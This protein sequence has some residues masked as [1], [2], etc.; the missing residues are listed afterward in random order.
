MAY[1][2]KVDIEVSTTSMEIRKCPRGIED[3]ANPV[4][5]KILFKVIVCKCRILSLV[6]GKK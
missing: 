6:F 5:L 1:K 4:S 2:T 3:C